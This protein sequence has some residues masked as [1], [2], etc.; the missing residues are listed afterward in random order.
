MSISR[1]TTLKRMPSPLRTDLCS[2][3]DW[4]APLRIRE[5]PRLVHHF[6]RLSLSPFPASS[7][8]PSPSLSFRAPL[9]ALI[10]SLPLLKHITF[11]EEGRPPPS[12][13][14]RPA[15]HLTFGQTDRELF[16]QAMQG[17]LIFWHL[18][19]DVA[20][21]FQVLQQLFAAFL[22]MVLW[23]LISA[24]P[25]D[26]SL[27]REAGWKNRV[28]LTSRLAYLTCRILSPAVLTLILVYI[29]APV[30][31]ELGQ[32][33]CATYARTFNVLLVP[34]ANAVPLVFIMRTLSLYE[35]QRRVAMPVLGLWG[36]VLVLSCVSLPYYGKGLDIPDGS[37]W[38][39]YDTQRKL[40]TVYNVAYKV[41]AL[42]QDVV[43]MLL[44]LHRLLQGGLQ[45]LLRPSGWKRFGMTS[46]SKVL[47]AQGFRFFVLNIVVD[48]IFIFFYFHWPAHLVSYQVAGAA[49][50]FSVPPMLAGK[51]FRDSKRVIVKAQL[52]E[53][54]RN[55]RSA[56]PASS[57][58]RYSA[59]TRQYR[60][61][62]LGYLNTSSDHVGLSSG[63]ATDR[64]DEYSRAANQINIL[65]YSQADL[66]SSPVQRTPAPAYASPLSP[67]GSDGSMKMEEDYL[68]AKRR[69][70]SEGGRSP[71]LPDTDSFAPANDAHLTL[72][73]IPARSHSMDLRYPPVRSR[74][75]GS[76]DSRLPVG[77]AIS[78][79]D[80]E[81][82]RRCSSY[83]KPVCFPSSPRSIDE[84]PF[85]QAAQISHGG[86]IT[87]SIGS[88]R[89]T[90]RSASQQ[91]EASSS[92]HACSSTSNVSRKSHGGRAS[93]ARRVKGRSSFGVSID[94]DEEAFGMLDGR[95]AVQTATSQELASASTNLATLRSRSAPSS[96]ASA[97][98]ALHCTSP[99]AMS[100]CDA[101]VGSPQ[102]RQRQHR[103]HE[104]EEEEE[105][106]EQDVGEAIS[107]S[108]T[109]AVGTFTR[110]HI[111]PTHSLDSAR[112]S[113]HRTPH[114]L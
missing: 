78:C 110:M 69:T 82:S 67:S 48:V 106:E 17:D 98:S 73:P 68:N 44:T 65:P 30:G 88:R 8:S 20:V 37:G 22:G 66:V 60:A 42:L 93:L 11:V 50:L 53:M 38:C 90:D 92:R 100:A 113:D 95:S 62:A 94:S 13:M 86:S 101:I 54:A 97:V 96:P 81:S 18:P 77:L 52:E 29:S 46:L 105:E 87:R 75:R 16:A 63:N 76:S 114:A 40:R 103:S 26:L 83:R 33:A 58:D 43:I 104:D 89:G 108:E 55:Q 41:P 49:L 39:H 27:L 84:R 71:R 111:L 31:R 102:Q 2:S 56:G 10:L 32:D 21:S 35:W 7:P 15:M 9:D 91:S 74:R 64:D 80:I 24:L 6:Q 4:G 112:R 72:P 14:A 99:P 19:K 23:D 107:D 57:D 51:V 1:S 34:L 59:R 3:P 70:P 85:S 79:E 12:N 61:G 25:F 47:I 5:S 109:E 36:I 45:S 28:K